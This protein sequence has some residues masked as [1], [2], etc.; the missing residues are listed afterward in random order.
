[1]TATPDPVSLGGLVTYSLTVT[2]TGGQ[3][4]S[5]VALHLRV[6]EGLYGS[7]GCR[8]VSDA[9]VLPGPRIFT[10]G[11]PIG[12]TGGHADPTDGYRQDL[13]GDPGPKDGIIN[14]PED[15]WKAVRQH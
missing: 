12:S 15:A 2:N 11:V 14:S 3:D 10:A 8:A 6:P 4:A 7:S 13:A 9:G 1:M 5:G